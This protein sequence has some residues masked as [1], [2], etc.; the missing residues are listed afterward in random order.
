MIVLEY[1]S[2]DAGSGVDYYQLYMS[3]DNGAWVPV[4]GGNADSVL[5]LGEAG[6]TY[7][8]Y[9]EAQDKT[10]NREKKNAVGEAMVSLPKETNNTQPGSMMLHPVPSNGTINL[11][12]DV[13]ETQQLIITVYSASGQRV[14]ELYNG[15]AASGNLKITKSL[16]NLSSGLYFVHARGSK[17]INQKKKLVL[18]K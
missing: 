13:P 1:G 17:G 3:E 18:V 14:A 12:L 10:G 4:P 15:T 8:F 5:L 6:K 9:M 2:T 16:Y 7:R 11:E